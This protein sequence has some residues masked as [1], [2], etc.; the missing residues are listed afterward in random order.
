MRS[1]LDSVSTTGTLA[2]GFSCLRSLGGGC[3][4]KGKLMHKVGSGENLQ[5]E[6]IRS[7]ARQSPYLAAQM[8]AHL[9]GADTQETKAERAAAAKAAAAAGRPHGRTRSA[10]APCAISGRHVPAP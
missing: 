1:G 5:A 10:H 3:T 9:S 4:K 2:R 6:A 7:L 8:Q